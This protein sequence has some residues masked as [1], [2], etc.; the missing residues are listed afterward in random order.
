M[1]V[2]VT[3]SAIVIL[4]GPLG[5]ALAEWISGRAG[6][7]PLIA[8]QIDQLHHELEE[9]KQRLAEAEERLDFTERLL[10]QQRQTALGQGG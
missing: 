2:L 9:V 5:R 1:S 4:R 10:A 3:V 6:A 8:G 7:D